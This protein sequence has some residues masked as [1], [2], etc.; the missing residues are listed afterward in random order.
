MIGNALQGSLIC[1]N[2]IYSVEGRNRLSTLD[3]AEEDPTARY[4][5]SIDAND[6]QLP[7]HV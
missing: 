2:D 6:A 3:D 5:R 4:Q 1:K 7:K